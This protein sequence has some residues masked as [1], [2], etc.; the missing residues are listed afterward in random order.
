MKKRLVLAF[1]ILLTIAT[2][3]SWTSPIHAQDKEKKE[4]DVDALIAALNDKDVN[5]RM[6]ALASLG[7]VGSGAKAAIPAITDL[8]KDKDVVGIYAASALRRIAPKTK[9]ALPV[10]LNALRVK[11]DTLRCFA[12]IAFEAFGVEAVRPLIDL[13][14]D[15]DPS[16]QMWAVSSVATIGKAAVPLLKEACRDTNPLVRSGAELALETIEIVYR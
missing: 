12:S 2:A 15:V 5:V 1:L 3:F 14:K 4:A 6:K 11:N 7:R 16:V 13:F 10:L 8:L 9:L